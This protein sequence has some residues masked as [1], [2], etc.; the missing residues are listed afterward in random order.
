MNP[1]EAIEV[2]NSRSHRDHTDWVIKTGEGETFI[3][4]KY[5]V[6]DYTF[7]FTPF[8]ANAIAMRYV[9]AGEPSVVS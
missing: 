8:E 5:Q 9:V 3:D 2:L 1:Q 4:I 7:R 6:E